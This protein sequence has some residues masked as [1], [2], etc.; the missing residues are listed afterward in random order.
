MAAAVPAALTLTAA[1]A[2]AVEVATEAEPLGGQ[3]C[4]SPDGATTSTGYNF[5]DD[6]TCGFDTPTDRQ[7]AGDPMLGAIITA[8]PGTICIDYGCTSGG[9]PLLAGSPLLDAIPLAHCQDDGGAGITTDTFNTFR[10]ARPQGSGC[11]IGAV[12]M[13]GGGTPPTPPPIE[14][15]PRFTG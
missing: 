1:P 7:D 6:S 3:N 12:E 9:L 2:G 13:P 14:T 10:D 4:F 11:D 8:P 5:S 15:P